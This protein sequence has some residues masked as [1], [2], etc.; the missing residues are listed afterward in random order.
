M[1]KV[2]LT[3]SALT[4]LAG[5]AA[6]E[7][8]VGGSARMGIISDSA[9]TRV[10]NRMRINVSGSGETD[11]G[12]T[13][14]AFARFQSGQAS[15][16]GT[17]GVMNG[18]G[19]WVSNGTM[20]L[21][22]GNQT[23]AIGQ[24]AGLYAVG[25]CGFSASPNY[26]QYCANVLN[27]G[28]AS[29][30]GFSS[31]GA[32]P[33]IARLDFALGSA[34]LSISGGTGNNMEVAASF[35]LG[36][37]NISVGY[38]NGAGTLGGT[39]LTVAFDAG[40]ANVAVTGYRD[41]AGTTSYILKG[42]MAA[43]SGN[44]GAFIARDLGGNRWGINYAQSLGGGATATVAVSNQATGYGVAAAGTTITAGLTFGF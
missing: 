1:K 16:L 31:G 7:M 22:V 38:D 43:G 17:T 35:A 21:S 10:E 36:S 23:G 8:N 19:V 2:L 3:T 40:S 34:N 33:S 39:Y 14:G 24:N 9:G 41:G 20:T 42:S 37:A 15:A 11:G 28:N 6:A 26:M 30:D 18:S 44:V 12:L 13:F 5:A 32:G 29:I 25:G 4:L 27:Q